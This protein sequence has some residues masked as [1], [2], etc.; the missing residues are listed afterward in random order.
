MD[1]QMPEMDGY[2]ASQ[3]IRELERSQNL[4]PTRI[5]AM[6]AHA[7]QGDCELC[8]A[9][10]MDDYLSKPVDTGKLKSALEK[11][12]RQKANN[13]STEHSQQEAH[14]KALANPR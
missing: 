6:T 10:G 7:M 9:S 1:C 3:K 14:S 12:G 5:I 11:A 8:L 13:E 2:E 4:T